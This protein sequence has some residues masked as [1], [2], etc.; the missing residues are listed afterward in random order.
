MTTTSK[1]PTLVLALALAAA[2]ALLAW[3]PAARGGGFATTTLDPLPAPPR[4]GA[5]LAVG[6]TVR[7]HGI[8]PVRVDGT[9]IAIVAADGTRTVFPGRPDGPAGHYVADVRFPAAG[10]WRWEADQGGYT[11][12]ALG[13]IEVAPGPPG[14]PASAAPA[15]DEG[16]GAAAWALLAATLAM[17][18]LLAVRVL[19]VV[20][21]RP[22]GEPAG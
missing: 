3:A 6:Y 7:Q 11:M 8:A 2:L 21:R 14:Q 18:G 13:E 10:A 5:T 17:A 19:G 12:Q 15:A 16:P 1:G 22:P 9:G 20:R 4:E